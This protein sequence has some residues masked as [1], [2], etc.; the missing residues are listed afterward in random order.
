MWRK[1]DQLRAE[2]EFLPWAKV[3]VRNISFR[4]R[5]KQVRDRHVFDDELVERLLNEEEQKEIDANHECNALMKCLDQLPAERR[6]L[7]LA[8]YRG[9]GAVKEMAEQATRSANSLYKILQRLRAKL[10]SCVETT[11]KQE[12]NA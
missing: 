11:M 10:L 12:A 3:I 7:I 9:P 1:L 8:P 4:H 2:S 6:E 5:R